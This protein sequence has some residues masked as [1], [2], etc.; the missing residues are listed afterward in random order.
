MQENHAHPALGEIYI[1]AV[2]QEY[3]G[4]GIGKL[5]TITA[6]NYLE[7]QGLRD[8]MLYV[9]FDNKTALHLYQ[10]LGFIQSGMDILYKLKA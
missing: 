6:L 9:D 10:S 7:Y 4:R 2:D 1:T 8:V 5:L 3:S